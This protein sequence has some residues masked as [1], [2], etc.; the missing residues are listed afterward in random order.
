MESQTEPRAAIAQAVG[1][2][3]GVRN[4]VGS[5][6]DNSGVTRV[7]TF[8][9]ARLDKLAKTRSGVGISA[10]VPL[11]MMN[12]HFAT[13]APLGGPTGDFCLVP[14]AASLTPLPL[15]PA[16]AWVPFDQYT[17]DGRPSEACQ[18]SFLKR[19]VTAAGERG[20]NF[21]MAYELEWFA[22]R[23][24]K[25]DREPFPSGPAV[26]ANAWA[27]IQS[28]AAE[29]LAALEAG[30]V[31]PD[32]FHPEYGLGQLELGLPTADPVRAAD[33]SVL[34]RHTIRTQA[35]NRGFGVSFA[36]ICSVGGGGNGCHLH[37]SLWDDQGRNLFSGGTERLGLTRDGE[38]FL[39]GVLNELPALVCI[40]CPSVLSYHRIQPE[41]WSGAYQSWGH[42][43]R[44][45]G[46]RFITGAAGQGSERANMEL[47]TVD[48]T[49]NPY[50]VPGAVIAAGFA[51]VDQEMRL[52]APLPDDPSRCSEA[53]L[54]QLGIHR[55]PAS[56]PEAIAALEAS[57]V[58]RAAMGDTML[59][60]FL[61]VRRA[62]WEAFG[63]LPLDELVENHLWR[64]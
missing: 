63:S 8:P 41:M 40:G 26:S 62:E 49:G 33:W 50:L 1:F 44:E 45:S 58:L 3:D 18:R 60:C 15:S 64:Y 13:D 23:D 27:E 37:F 55:L 34:V 30:G 14:D 61:A 4:V 17:Q 10:I 7:K 21:L 52:P 36:P 2:N 35:A 56:L 28:L 31:V 53:E 57:E 24:K 46:L 54:E 9:I 59:D 12:D 25:G 51:G 20:Y 39:A 29:L 38:A 19:M 47:K 32:V 42:E 16:W 5:F 48:L 43:N 22:C 6:V 11:Y